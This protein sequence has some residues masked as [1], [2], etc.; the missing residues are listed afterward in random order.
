LEYNLQIEG[1]SKQYDNFKLNNISFN[2]PKGCIMGFIGENGAGKTTTIN[3]LLNLIKKDSG[4]IKIFGL[5]NIQKEKEFK[6]QI[7]VVLD[8][9]F[10]HDNLK[11]TDI[12]RIMKNTYKTWDN[13]LF[14]QYLRKF[15]IPENKIIKELSK[16]MR[17]KLEIATALGHKPKLLILDE[18]T[19][20]L[21]PVIRNEILDIF[22]DFIQDEENSILISSHITTD[23]EKVADY[24]TFIHDGNIIFCETKD[25]L[26]Y[27]YGILKCGLSDFD[28]IDKDDYISYRKNNFGY[29]FLVKNKQE[30][31]YKYK[32]Y[33]VDNINIEDIMLFY[34]KGTEK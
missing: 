24:I 20:G 12:S 10:F 16:G 33:I 4:N 11:P 23:L 28:K 27:S 9:S 14:N 3:L 6:E 5:D 31:K 8:E 1:L 26:I 22:L 30:A 21:D 34:I 7:G 15:K 29:E 18:A 25:N 19:S 13:A 2:L 32:N 17:A